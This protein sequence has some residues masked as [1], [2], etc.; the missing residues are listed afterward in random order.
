MRWRHPDLGLVTAAEF[1]TA[2][3]QGGLGRRLAEWAINEACRQ[4]KEWHDAGMINMRVAVNLS[5]RQFNDPGTVRVV[6]RA[7]DDAGLTGRSLEV[8]VPE[9]SLADGKNA[10]NILNALKEIGILLAIDD[11]GS[12]GCSFLDLKSMPIDTIKIAPMFVQNMVHRTDDAAIVQAMITMAKGLDLRVVA[13]GV[14]TK[15]Q[16]SYLLNRRCVEM[17]GFFLGKPMPAAALADVL[18]MQH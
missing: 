8:E 4:A 3:E 10:T 2:A 9:I 12:G 13:E 16:L 17:Q 15:E 18:R 1:L 11:Y 7:V 14:E 6:E 5:N